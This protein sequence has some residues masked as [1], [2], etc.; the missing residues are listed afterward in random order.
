MRN[1]QTHA[2]PLGIWIWRPEDMNT[3]YRNSKEAKLYSTN[4]KDST[5]SSYVPTNLFYDKTTTNSQFK[6]YL[7]CYLFTFYIGSKKKKGYNAMKKKEL[8]ILKLKDTVC[9]IHFW[10]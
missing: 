9:V 3:M 1:S 5:Y 7:W 4:N 8:T 6:S 10:F 2:S